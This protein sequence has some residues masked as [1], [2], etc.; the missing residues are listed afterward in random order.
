MGDI[1]GKKEKI[2]SFGLVPIPA[3]KSKAMLSRQN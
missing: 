3:S 1:N 2:Y